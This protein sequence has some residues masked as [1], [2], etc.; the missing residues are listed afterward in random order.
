MTQALKQGSPEWHDARVG[1][2]TASCFA[3]AMGINP[4]QSRQKLYDEMTG[5][6]DP[7]TGNEMTQWGEDHEPDA[8]FA[9]EA[10]IGEFVTPTGFWTHP[11]A[12]WLGASPDGLV[13]NSGLIE[14]KC[15]F[16]QELWEE[17]PAHYM[18]QIQGQLEITDR[19][20]CDFVSW[21]PTDLAVFRVDRSVEYWEAQFLLLEEF[22]NDLAN[23]QKPKRRKKPVM[24]AVHV[25]R[26]K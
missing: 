21:T 12:E 7:F 16:S 9:Y 22:W 18:A 6:A 24:P 13:V 17:V 10:F 11:E 26:L 2:L 5:T 15:K 25:E 20:W 4:Y 1:R 19:A 8:I 23:R 3:A 14:C